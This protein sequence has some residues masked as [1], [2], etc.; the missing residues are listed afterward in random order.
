MTLNVFI[1][2]TLLLTP[3]LTFKQNLYYKVTTGEQKGN[4]STIIFRMH[5]DVSFTR[6]QPPINVDEPIYI[7]IQ[8][9]DD[10]PLIDFDLQCPNVI[11]H[12]PNPN[13]S[14][15]RNLDH[16][17]NNLDSEDQWVTNQSSTRTLKFTNSD[18]T[19][20]KAKWDKYLKTLPFVITNIKSTFIPKG[21]G[22]SRNKISLKVDCVDKDTLAAI[23]SYGAVYDSKKL[24]YY[25][26]DPEWGLKL[27]AGQRDFLINVRQNWSQKMEQ[28][29]PILDF[30]EQTQNDLIKAIEARERS[31]DI[32]D[33][34]GIGVHYNISGDIY[35]FNEEN[36]T[37]DTMS[38][39]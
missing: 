21:Q 16:P 25:L 26:D 35:H 1:T 23:E 34:N 15:E 10:L 11:Y 18:L 33:N 30:D 39:I 6:G 19:D 27:L 36:Q 8:S 32:V 31:V 2:L 12:T 37:L 4:S 29:D 20:F 14:N 38:Y 13:Y 5:V 22:Q 9:M 3:A 7:N 24:E 28:I 17:E